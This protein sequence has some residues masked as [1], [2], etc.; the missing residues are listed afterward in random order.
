MGH[1]LFFGLLFSLLGHCYL[2]VCIEQFK[3][4]CLGLNYKVETVFMYFV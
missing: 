3:I 1:C 4:C 2:H